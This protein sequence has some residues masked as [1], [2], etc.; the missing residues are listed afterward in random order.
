MQDETRGTWGLADRNTNCTVRYVKRPFKMTFINGSGC[1]RFRRRG[2]TFSLSGRHSPAPELPGIVRTDHPRAFVFV[3]VVQQPRILTR[4]N[5]SG[6]DA[7]A[8]IL[9]PS[10][11]HRRAIHSPEELANIPLILHDNQIYWVVA[12]AY[13]RQYIRSDRSRDTLHFRERH[14]AQIAHQVGAY[15][16]HPPRNDSIWSSHFN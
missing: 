6:V 5:T 12:W 13:A 7:T 11:P 16:L 8:Q 4:P 15:D 10:S 1:T 9:Q 2:C 14:T 3:L